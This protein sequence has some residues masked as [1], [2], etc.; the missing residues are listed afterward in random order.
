MSL[1]PRGPRCEKH[2]PIDQPGWRA[3]GD[4]KCVMCPDAPAPT[5]ALVTMLVKLNDTSPAYLEAVIRDALDAVGVSLAPCNWGPDMDT[6]EGACD[7]AFGD[8]TPMELSD[9]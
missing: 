1:V 5:Y 7:I 2:V 9:F 4:E 6:V 8:V 3:S